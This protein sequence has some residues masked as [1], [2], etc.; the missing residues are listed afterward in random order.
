[1]Y[2]TLEQGEAF[3]LGLLRHDAVDDGVDPRPKVL[4]TGRAHEPDPQEVLVAPATEAAGQ[5][6]VSVRRIEVCEHIPDQ[7]GDFYH[8]EALIPSDIG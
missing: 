6:R 5:F 8:D 4:V 1:V 7:C 2:A 3:R